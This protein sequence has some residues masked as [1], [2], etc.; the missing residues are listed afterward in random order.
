MAHLA[1]YVNHFGGFS[2]YKDTSAKYFPS[3][4]AK[5]EELLI[6]LRKAEK[7]IFME[8]F[9]VAEGYMWESILRDLKSK[10]ERG[11]GSPFSL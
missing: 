5:F 11:R 4:E 10:G 6:Q 7:F 9:I 1:R 2:V 8:Y 3:G